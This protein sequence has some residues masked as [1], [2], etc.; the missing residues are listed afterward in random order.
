MGSLPSEPGH[1]V[2]AALAALGRSSTAPLTLAR[3]PLG[4]GPGS[5][6]GLAYPCDP[7]T[8]RPGLGGMF[9]ADSLG[10]DVLTAADEDLVPVAAVQPWGDQLA[11]AVATAQQSRNYLVRLQFVVERGHLWVLAVDAARLLAHVLVRAVAGLGRRGALD[12]RQCLLAV[13]DA[14][15]A[16]AT[17][18]EADLD[19]LV[20]AAHGLGVS[21][22]AAAGVAVFSA[23]DAVDAAKR[24]RSPVLVLT[25]SRP[26]DLPGLLAAGAVVTERGGRT[27]HAA[28][29]ARGLDR[30]AVTA[31]RDAVVDRA[32]GRLVV[33]YGSAVQAGDEVT[34]D[35]RTG[36]VYRGR[37]GGGARTGADDA[38]GWLTG[39]AEGPAAVD[40][41]VNADSAAD[42][43]RGRQAGA[44][45][46]G[47][48]RIE[49]MFLG[50]RRMLL[51]RA[52][53]NAR[54]P[55]APAA[56][57]AVR[58]ALRAE[59]TALLTAMD[60]LPVAIRLIDA[61]RHEFLPDLV[62]LTALDAAARARGERPPDPER[63]GAV[64]RLNEHQ[65]LLGTR[66][67]RL[68]LLTPDLTAAQLCALVEATAAVR[69]AGGTPRP[70][71]LVPMVSTPAE[72]DAVRVQLEDVRADNGM[73]GGPPIPLGAM[74]ETPRAALLAGALAERV[75]FLSVGTNDLTSLTWGLSRDDAERAL[76]PGYL[77]LGLL[78][79]S[80]FEEL[81]VSGV[82]A[83]IRQ[84]VAAARA[85]RPE[86]PVGV[87][88]EHAGAP[89]AVRVLADLGVDY[90]SCVS[91]QVPGARFAAARQAVAPGRE[92]PG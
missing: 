35:G 21:A 14:A 72:V 46:V 38:V 70:E 28:V 47:L 83:L 34:V 89:G 2:A 66:G 60:G 51:E 5:G 57:T 56:L 17:Q 27:S 6:V 68:G 24:G 39:L 62:D 90:V 23:A 15:L 36:V 81:D 85:V 80:P 18:P 92:A 48:A 49:H 71:L 50:E 43:A 58:S 8:G 59:I 29:V 16:T 3:M 10:A 32:A 22:G 30:P 55:D 88:G 26:E 33:P 19:G 4:L 1:Q 69:R 53:L 63:L 31:L 25:E 9:R 41:R 79:A 7:R 86:L 52:M 45:G 73:S 42:A 78:A 84:A 91:P 20:P 37:P 54:G 12:R 13:D 61:P 64:R 44:V 87:C 75:D 76:I 82:G 11:A 77:R 74:V 65:P 67:V 40:V